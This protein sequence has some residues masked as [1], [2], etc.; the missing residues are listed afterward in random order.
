MAFTEDLDHFFDV[1]NGFAVSATILGSEVN[2]IFNNG[3]TEADVS[4]YGVQASD[5]TFTAKSADIPSGAAKGVAIS[6][7]GQGAWT[8]KD[9]QPDGAGITTIGVTKN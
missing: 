8:I 6:I 7:T 9:M 3:Y 4:T 5:P 2:G 1:E